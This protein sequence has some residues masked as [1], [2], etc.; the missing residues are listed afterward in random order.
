MNVQN[1]ERHPRSK[2]VSVTVRQVLVFLPIENHL[3]TKKGKVPY[4]RN[5]QTIKLFK[6][7]KY[8]WTFKGNSNYLIPGPDKTARSKPLTAL[9]LSSYEFLLCSRGCPQGF[10][11]INSFYSPNTPGR[12]S[13]HLHRTMGKV[14]AQKDEGTCPGSHIRWGFFGY[15]TNQHQWTP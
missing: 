12:Y 10:P 1:D 6:Y 5:S 8:I 3:I 9:T 13:Q 7:T 2:W 15:K 4:F 14:E 11:C